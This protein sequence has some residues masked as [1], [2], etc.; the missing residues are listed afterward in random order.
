MEQDKLQLVLQPKYQLTNQSLIGY[1]AL[2]RWHDSELGTVPPDIFVAV[3]ESV[4]LGKALDC[5]VIKTVL[6]QI[7]SWQSMGLQP[8]PV[9]VNITAKHF[10]DPAL[11]NFIEAKLS[12]LG[13]RAD[14]L[15]LEIT[16]GVVMDDSPTIQDNLSA[17]RSAGIKVAID[18]F[19]TGYSL[20]SYLTTLPI[21]FIKIDRA[22]IQHLEQGKNLGLVK[23]MLT[24]AQALEVA[25]IAE[26]IE[27][28]QQ[29]E[30]LTELGCEFGQGFFFARPAG[31][32]EIEQSLTQQSDGSV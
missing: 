23:A 14:C 31:L 11:Y 28:Q 4:N 3:A 27:T 12:K 13:L 5:W 24:M 21:D 20:L 18:D 10:S 19:G 17:C 1:E 9:A 29:H 7:K 15:Q 25:V 22:F 32:A 30:L 8:K 16:E 2:L 26:G 6:N